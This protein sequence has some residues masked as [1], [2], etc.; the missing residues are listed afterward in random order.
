MYQQEDTH[1]DT[2][3]RGKHRNNLKPTT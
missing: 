1:S 3:W 2:W